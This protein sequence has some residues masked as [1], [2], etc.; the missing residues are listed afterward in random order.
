MGLE[1][2]GAELVVA[3]DDARISLLRP[4]GAVGDG[5][6]LEDPVLLGLEVGVV[7]GL[8]GLQRLKGHALLSE[9][10]AQA[11]VADVVDHPLSHEVV[12]Q[13][14]QRPGGE[15]QPVVGGPAQGDGLDLLALGQGEL[16]RPAPRIA[17][18]EGIEA[19]GV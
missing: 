17:G 16:R 14:R 12:G 3:D 10:R 15:G 4:L 5:V 2:Q 19:V 11:L 8:P 1:V 9:K 6:E 7:R 18:L 13:L